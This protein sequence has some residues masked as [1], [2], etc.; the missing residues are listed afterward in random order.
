MK[1]G[2]IIAIIIGIIVL[3]GIVIFFVFN[4]RRNIEINEIKKLTFRHDPG[5]G[6]GTDY[7][8]ICKDKCYANYRY[9]KDGQHIEEKEI[10]V[11]DK[12]IQELIKGL[13]KY[14]VS[15]WNGFN[16][17]S[18]QV[19]DALSFH[20]Y[21]TIQENKKILAH[22]YAYKP[23]NYNEVKELLDEIF[24]KIEENR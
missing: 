3:L 1:K 22:G 7:E 20:M 4:S 9:W 13:N 5:R 19:Y 12:T 10:P 18:K 23:K 2:Y 14:K 24:N 15:R 16:R 8:I 11:D 17:I 6:N 21:L